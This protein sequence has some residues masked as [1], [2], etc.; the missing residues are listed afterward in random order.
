MTKVKL[1]QRVSD[2]IEENKDDLLDLAVALFETGHTEDE[3]IRMV[4]I[5]VDAIIDWVAIGS[6][7]GPIGTAVGVFVEKFDG[8]VAIALVKPILRLA[9]K[10][11]K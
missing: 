5:R 3:V 6:L 11:R 1:F 8:P 4:V 7:A 2:T 10:A 9:R